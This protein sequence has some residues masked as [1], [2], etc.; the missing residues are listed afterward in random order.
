MCLLVLFKTERTFWPTIP[1]HPFYS[2]LGPSLAECLLRKPSPCLWQWLQKA[3]GFP[4]LVHCW[5][6]KA[7]SQV[8]FNMVRKIK[9]AGRFLSLVLN[10]GFYSKFYT[11]VICSPLPPPTGEEYILMCTLRLLEWE[12]P[13]SLF[14]KFP[15]ATRVVLPK[16]SHTARLSTK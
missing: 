13:Q 3:L 10:C 2:F 6:P 12:D 15:G 1:H 7:V 8:S 11:F 4:W 9:G 16:A 14:P 5:G